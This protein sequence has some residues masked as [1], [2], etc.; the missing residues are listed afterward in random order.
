M[1]IYSRI[2]K[3][4]EEQ[5]INIKSLEVASGLG[6]GTVSNWKDKDPKTIENMLRICQ[7]LGVTMNDIIYDEPPESAMNDVENMNERM[8]LET[9]RSLSSEGKLKLL[10]E[11]YG[12]MSEEQPSEERKRA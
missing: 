12:L 3:I 1:D 5:G 6:N 9:Y 8:L 4:A 11:A 2:A 7:T 10:G